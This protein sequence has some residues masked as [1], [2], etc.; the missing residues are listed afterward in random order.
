MLKVV[1]IGSGN[2]AQQL[3]QVFE[4]TAQ[5]ELVQL[6]ARNPEKVAHLVPAN[7]I[8]SSIINLA[9]AD[10][11]IIAVA[12]DAI[13]E[14]SSQ[15]SFTGRLVVHTSGSAAIKQI[16]NRNRRGVFYPLQTFSKSKKIDFSTIPFCL[17]T[18][19]EEDYAIL[20]QLADSISKNVYRI[21][22]TQRQSLHVAAVFVS[23]FSNH[24][25]AI[26]NKICDEHNIPF[27]ILKPLIT[28]TADK[29]KILS[30]LQAQTG[31][32]KRN[33]RSTIEKHLDFLE[34]ENH[35]KIYAI[36]TKSIQEANV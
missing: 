30:P 34:D 36:L 5:V 18:E 2:V 33:D 7:R 22:T 8:T 11:Y 6:Y 14:V 31:P 19:R 28:E 12:D 24:M 23:N 26:G 1:V 35:K 17:E 3:V 10:I 15:L 9:E 20:R 29:I 16:D 21:N 4:D 32:A 13:A 27:D 25:Y